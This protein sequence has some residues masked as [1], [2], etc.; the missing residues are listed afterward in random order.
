MI[1]CRPNVKT[2]EDTAPLGSVPSRQ[3]AVSMTENVAYPAARYAV[4][5]V[6]E[7]RT[8]RTCGQETV[9]EAGDFVTVRGA[10]P[11]EPDG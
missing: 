11:Q 6:S 9:I 8:H 10:M 2:L 7:K 5:D 4:N 1:H 3:Q